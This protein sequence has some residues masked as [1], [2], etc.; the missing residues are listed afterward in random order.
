MTLLSTLSLGSAPDQIEGSFSLHHSVDPRTSPF[1]DAGVSGFYF[2]KQKSFVFLI[3]Y[4]RLHD[5]V[6]LNGN[7]TV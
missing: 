5:T 1:S 4:L 6:V 2:K 3:M 7:R